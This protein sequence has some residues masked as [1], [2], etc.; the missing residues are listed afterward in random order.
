[1]QPSLSGERVVT[2]S[3]WFAWN[4]RIPGA[5]HRPRKIT[6][7]YRAS[8]NNNFVCDSDPRVDKRSSADEYI[9]PNRNFTSYKW[10]PSRAEVVGTSAYVAILGNNRPCTNRYGAKRVKVSPIAN[11]CEIM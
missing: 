9:P 5:N 11:A 7:N 2:P 3:P 4:T 6:K 8:A 1:M 10:H